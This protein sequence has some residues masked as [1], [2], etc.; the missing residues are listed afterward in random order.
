MD[1]DE[2]SLRYDELIQSQPGDCTR[3]RAKP[4]MD[5]CGCD[6]CDAFDEHMMT[7]AESTTGTHTIISTSTILFDDLC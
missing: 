2:W 6:W 5:S 7:Y 1:T 3:R 4:Y